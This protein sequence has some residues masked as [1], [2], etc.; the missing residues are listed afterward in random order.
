MFS[1][2]NILKQLKSLLFKC[3]NLLVK[4][5]GKY[6]K[7]EKKVSDTNKLSKIRIQ[8]KLIGA[9]LIP[10]GFIILL[11]I[12]SFSKASNALISNYKT[13][14][15]SNMNNMASYIDLGL[16][17]VAEKSTLLNTNST[18]KNYYSS[19]YSNNV[20]GEQRKYKELQEFVFANILSANI[21]KNIY[22][23]GEYGNGILTHGSAN[24]S[25]YKDFIK[26]KEGEAFVQSGDKNK[27][28]GNHTFL[29]E[30]IQTDKADYALSYISYIYSNTNEKA[31]FVILDVSMGFIKDTLKNSGLPKESKVV[32]VSSDG[33]EISRESDN[34]KDTFY[35]NDYY[36]KIATNSN[37]KSGYDNITINKKKYLFLYSYVAQCDSYICVQI[38]QNVI[39]NQVEGVKNITVL[40]VLIASLVAIIFGTF[41][42]YGISDTIKRINGVLECTASGNLTIKV[43]MRRRDEFLLLGNGINKLIDSIKE[44]IRDMAKVSTTVLVSSSEVSENSNILYH[45][46]QNISS[47]VD[48]VKHGIASQSEGTE[49]CLLQMSDL[50]VQ[51]GTLYDNALSIRKS[52][53]NTKAVINKGMSVIEDLGMKAQTSSN[54]VKSV[55]SNI[56][57]LEQKSKDISNIIKS[58]NNISEQTNL[59]S[60]N[61]TIEAARAG[62]E[63]KGFSVV[64]NEI[65]KLSEQSSNEAERINKIINQ[66]QNQ[67]QK[68]VSTAKR[69]EDQEKLSGEALNNAISIFMEIDKNVEA[70]TTNLD[71][72][73]VGIKGIENAKEDTL[74]A[75]EEISAISEQTTAAMDQLSTTAKEQLKAVEALYQ[76][77][78]EMGQDSSVLES[79]INIFQTEE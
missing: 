54:I 60:L 17:Q 57:N 5:K 19:S 32:F 13:S 28:L 66:I 35:N 76:A 29:D 2:P 67:T 8:V 7:A 42:S 43:K 61:A 64:A 62:K 14:T 11:G 3:K 9:F 45:T 79:K 74:G 73:V 30:Q 18:L 21:I 77:V 75:V 39:T 78:E 41:I 50:A 34:G 12:I 36:K 49:S 69:A 47:A 38:P 58:I 53:D 20:I 51:I 24:A 71:N 31:G 46:T 16:E 72:I 6:I 63:G 59:L 65:K 1:T 23:F 27:W 33:K 40:I 37:K 56:E 52:A 44:L 4:L 55:I 22:I 48:D 26:E 25:L 70:L 68:T 10:V 15:L